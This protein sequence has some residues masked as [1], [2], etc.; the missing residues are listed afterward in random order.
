MN[1]HLLE[2]Y[3]HRLSET[4]DKAYLRLIVEVK[5]EGVASLKAR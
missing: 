5:R 1:E 3:L 4:N 2:Y